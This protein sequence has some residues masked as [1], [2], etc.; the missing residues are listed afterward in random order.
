MYIVML[1]KRSGQT[2]ESVDYLL[3]GEL[4][5]SALSIICKCV[6]GG[7]FVCVVTRMCCTA[8]MICCGVFGLQCVPDHTIH[9]SALH[10]DTESA[11]C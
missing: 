7:V 11:Q 3:H 9:H 5:L 1:A 6:R 10:K 2:W 4:L 8:G